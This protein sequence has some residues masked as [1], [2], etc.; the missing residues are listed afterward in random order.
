MKYSVLVF[1]LFQEDIIRFDIRSLYIY[2]TWTDNPTCLNLK[3]VIIQS[4]QGQ[5]VVT[6]WQGLC[7]FDR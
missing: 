2:S 1:Y 6:L 4:T 3:W 5:R 7:S